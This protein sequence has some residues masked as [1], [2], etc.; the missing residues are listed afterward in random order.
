MHVGL[1][2]APGPTGGMCREQTD[3]FLSEDLETKHEIQFTSAAI[4]NDWAKK[5]L[6]V[7]NE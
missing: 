2:A 6:R 1:Q 5:R 3:V 7:I 4:K